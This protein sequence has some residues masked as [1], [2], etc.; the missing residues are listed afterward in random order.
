MQ[1]EQDDF[2]FDH[3]IEECKQRLA[4]SALAYLAALERK[5]V[6]EPGQP[7]FGPQSTGNA[8]FVLAQHNVDYLM[9]IYESLGFSYNDAVRLSKIR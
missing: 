6:T 5:P 1:E 9:L 4:T 8:A 7:L 3:L 2:T